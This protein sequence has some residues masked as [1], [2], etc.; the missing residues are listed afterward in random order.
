MSVNET[1]P[2]TNTNDAAF[3]KDFR[4]SDGGK[5]GDSQAHRREP[6]GGVRSRREGVHATDGAGVQV[7]VLPR[8]QL[9]GTGGIS[10]FHSH[11]HVFN[12]PQLVWFY[13]SPPVKITFFFFNYKTFNVF[14]IYFF[15]R[16]T[17]MLFSKGYILMPFNVLFVSHLSLD[18]IVQK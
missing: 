8:V 9:S 1:K 6:G 7:A 15:A 2:F 12:K 10:S 5:R 13:H 11:Q 3:H 17:K 18:S 4:P 14:F 16:H